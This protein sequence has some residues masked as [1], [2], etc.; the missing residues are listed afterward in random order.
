[1]ADLLHALRTDFE[2]FVE[3]SFYE[4]EGDRLTV[5]P[6][7]KYLCQQ[8]AGLGPGD[9]HAINLPPRHLKTFL[10]SVCLSAWLLGRN[11]RTKIM[12]IAGS[13]TLAEEI[14][15]RVRDLV[16]CAW[17]RKAFPR[18]GL[19]RSKSRKTD[20]AMEEG[21]GLYATSIFSNI[22]GRGANFIIVDDPLNIDDAANP[23][24]VEKVN[25]S[26]DRVVTNRLNNQKTGGILIVMHRLNDNDLCGHVFAQGG[27]KRTVLPLIAPRTRRYKLS[28]ETWVRH[29]GELLRPDA[30]TPKSIEKLRK[31]SRGPDFELLYQQNPLGS[32]FQRLKR[33]HFPTF[34]QRPD[35]GIVLSVDP[36]HGGRGDDAS[37]NV[38]QAWARSG[39][40]YFLI[41]Q[42][43]ERCG[44]G[45][46]RRRCLA[47]MRRYRPGAILIERTGNG[48]AL[49][50]DLR[51]RKRWRVEEVIPSESKLERFRRVASLFR[52]GKVKLFEHAE[53]RA[54]FV[55]EL[56]GFPNAPTDDQTDA[57]T[58]ALSWMRD[59]PIVAEPPGRAIIAVA[60]RGAAGSTTEVKGGVL[61]RRRSVTGAF[62][63]HQ[64]SNGP[65]I[66]PK[67]NV[68][69]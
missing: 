54:D 47:L 24:A 41:D 48:A 8:L 7:I 23:D 26:F 3:K 25:A 66:Q 42:W 20:F 10:A 11:P 18:A 49:I 67:V 58:Q 15:R 29:E 36:S 56:V 27:W 1:M 19:S 45:K 31:I 34:E 14:S 13:E 33:E 40:E 4:L 9:R 12:I 61:S 59:N 60:N 17:Y 53:W 28:G 55:D 44:Y 68:R 62:S 57:A 39:D 37:F 30:F 46:L 65:F 22:T 69:Y 43:R 52:A 21:G 32:S 51:E 5:R 38:V 16:C 2:A 63:D 64:I 35:V 50:S 6:Y